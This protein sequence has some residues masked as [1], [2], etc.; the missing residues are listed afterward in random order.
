[1]T[2]YGCAVLLAVVAVGC[3]SGQPSARSALALAHHI[4]DAALL[5]PGARPTSQPAPGAIGGPGTPEIANLEDVHQ[6]WTVNADAHAEWQWLEGHRRA[7]FHL[8]GT[9]SGTDRG[10]PSWGVTDELTAL[11]S[12]VSYAAVDYEIARTS[13]GGAYIRV[14][15]TV[16][17]TAPRPADEFLHASD[18][19]VVTVLHVASV[20]GKRVVVTDPGQVATIVRAFNQLHVVPSSLGVKYG[21]PPLTRRTVSYQVGFGA[22]RD[23]PTMVATLG[24]CGPIGVTVDGR[25]APSLNMYDSAGSAF[26]NDVAHVLG[27][28]EPHFG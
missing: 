8:I 21:C 4:L 12:N 17:W 5:P 13:A 22:A 15:A 10:V 11:P 18:Q 19:V 3:S 26:A 16:D 2:R 7:G 27:L 9:D 28:T 6:A 23:T 20:P 24:Q 1:M 25:G 14:D